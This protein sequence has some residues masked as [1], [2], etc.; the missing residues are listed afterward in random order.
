MNSIA[1]RLTAC[2]AV[3]GLLLACGMFSSGGS[4]ATISATS[5]PDCIKPDE[6]ALQTIKAP[7]SGKLQLEHACLAK[8]DLRHIDLT[9][10]NLVGADLAGADLRYDSLVGAN[11][12]GADLTGTDLRY[13]TLTEAKLTGAT[14]HGA[15]L[16]YAVLKSAILTESDLSGA[17]FGYADLEHAQVTNDQL[18]VAQNLQYATMPDGSS[19]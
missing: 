15:D 8:A 13:A 9:G 1:R 6:A 19:R 2:L 11:L 18:S 17:D 5:R 16:R 10:A 3:S 14:L 4:A 12:A 7:H